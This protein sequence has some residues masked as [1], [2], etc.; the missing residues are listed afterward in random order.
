[1]S[2]E[3]NELSKDLE[4]VADANPHTSTRY[5]VRLQVVRHDML[6]PDSIHSYPFWSQESDTL[7]DHTCAE[8]IC[9]ET[10]ETLKEVLQDYTETDARGFM[11]AVDRLV[12]E[13]RQRLRADR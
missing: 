2:Q 12:E 13:G 11:A 5:T 3:Y 7:R 4:K 10:W 6:K 9:Q 1:M 8:L